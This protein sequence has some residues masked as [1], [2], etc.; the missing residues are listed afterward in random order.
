MTKSPDQ[1]L[2]RL[3]SASCARCRASTA[4]LS[5]Y[6]SDVWRDKR[7]AFLVRLKT[8]GRI[9]TTYLQIIIDDE[10]RPRILAYVQEF[11][12]E[13]MVLYPYLIADYQNEVQ[14]L[15]RDA[16]LRQASAA[17]IRKAYQEVCKKIVSYG[18]A[19]GVAPAKKIIQEIQAAYPRK[20]V[21][22]EELCLTMMEVGR[23]ETP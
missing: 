3:V 16:L 17:S 2:D 23:N 10:D 15:F 14:M 22:Q 5:T 4:D 19:C 8:G 20:S 9:H 21:F 11:P 12:D 13:I 6:P 18:R 7:E 1:A